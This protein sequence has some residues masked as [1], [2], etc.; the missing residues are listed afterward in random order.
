MSRPRK[1]TVALPIRVAGP[2]MERL[3]SLAAIVGNMSTNSLASDIIR[4]ALELINNA[5]MNPPMPYEMIRLREKLHGPGRSGTYIS[6][7]YPEGVSIKE[8]PTVEEKR[9]STASEMEMLDKILGM[10]EKLQNALLDAH[11]R[12]MELERKGGA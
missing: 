2:V 12:I 9:A 8:E 10:N 6:E 5:E 1:D 11:S 4:M 7:P 3:E